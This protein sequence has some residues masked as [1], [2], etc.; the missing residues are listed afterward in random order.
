[1]SLAPRIYT[2]EELNVVP[3][4]PIRQEMPR[5]PG[6]VRLGGIKGVMEIIINEQGRFE[7]GRM[8][9]SVDPAYDNAL[10]TAATKWVYR[11]ATADGMPVK[12]LRRIQVNIAEAK[13]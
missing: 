13:P 3:P 7:S 6:V 10:L 9:V 11:P 12:F 1:M 8:R 2:G 5:Y 4:V